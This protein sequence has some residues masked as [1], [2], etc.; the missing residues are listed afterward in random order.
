MDLTVRIDVGI[1]PRR[2]Q[3]WK[4]SQSAA[5]SKHV[6]WRIFAG[7]SLVCLQAIRSVRPNEMAVIRCPRPQILLASVA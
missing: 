4:Q 5:S 7:K 1:C 6:R 2:P 3:M